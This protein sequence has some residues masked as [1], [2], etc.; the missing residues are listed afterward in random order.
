MWRGDYVTHA[1]SKGE[2]S[3]SPSR[4]C[5]FVSVTTGEFFLEN[6]NTSHNQSVLRTA[7]RRVK[8]NTWRASLWWCLGSTTTLCMQTAIGTETSQGLTLAL[9]RLKIDSDELTQCYGFTIKGNSNSG[10]SVVD[11]IMNLPFLLCPHF[12]SL[13]MSLLKPSIPDCFV[14]F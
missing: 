3:I 6:N 4:L 11:S 5:P 9:C 13:K 2:W 14:S 10:T 1:E 12:L 7:G 8:E